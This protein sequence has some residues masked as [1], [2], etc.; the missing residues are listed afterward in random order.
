MLSVSYVNDNWYNLDNPGMAPQLGD[1]VTNLYDSINPGLIEAIYGFN[2]FGSTLHFDEFDGPVYL[3]LPGASLIHDA[4]QSAAPG[5]TVQLLDGTFVESD[6]VIDRPLTLAGTVTGMLNQ[7]SVIVPEVTSAASSADFGVGTRQGIIIYSPSV[8][9]S[10]VVVNGSGSFATLGSQQYHQGITTIYDLQDGGSYS[11]LRNGL[12][13]PITLGSSYRFANE[14]VPSLLIDNVAVY[15]SSYRGITLSPLADKTWDTGP[16]QASPLQIS[17]SLVLGIGNFETPGSTSTGIVLQ[18]IGNKQSGVDGNIVNTFVDRVGI[19]ILT[20]PFGLSPDFGN[21]NAAHNGATLAGNTV[22]FTQSVGYQIEF[23]SAED[24]VGNHFVNESNMPPAPL[25]AVGFSINH[26]R[27]NFRDTFVKGAQKGFLVQN[28][29]FD[30]GILPT[31]GFGTRLQ[32]R[33]GVPADIGVYLQNSVSSPHSAAA[34]IGAGASFQ[35]YTVAV[36]SSQLTT[37][38]DNRQNQLVV[39][40]PTFTSVTTPFELFETE[41]Q[42]QVTL[43]GGSPQVVTS[44]SVLAP[45]FQN[46]GYYYNS[47]GNSS[48]GGI[49]ETP[50]TAA[51]FYLGNGELEDGTYAPL[52]TGQSGTV[53]LF[54]FNS[55]RTF[56]FSGGPPT[57]PAEGYMLVPTAAT[58]NWW[59]SVV[60][61]GSGPLQIM[62]G[63]SNVAGDMVFDTF[64]TPV[65]I[66]GVPAYQLLPVD[67][68]AQSALQVA[69]RKTAGNLSKAFQVGLIDNRGNVMLYAFPFAD[70]TSTSYTTL[71]VNL[72]APSQVLTGPDDH[73]DFTKVVGYVITSDEGEYDGIT[74][75][76]G[77]LVDDISAVG[78]PN[79]VIR[80]PQASISN[81]ALAPELRPS[82]VPSI[83]QQFTIVN[84]EGVDPVTGTFAG[85]AE[86]SFVTIS[87]STYKISYTGGSGN[88]VV[89]TREDVPLPATVVGRRL[90][91]NQSGTASPLRYDGNNAAIN[92]YDDLAIATDKSAYLPGSGASTFANV[93]SYTKGINGIMIDIAGS[94][95]TIT[96]ADFI[97]RVGN[98]N[99]PNSWVA[100]PAPNSISVR[101]GAGIGGSDRVVLTWANG[102]I[103]KKWLEVIVLAN[104]N[105]GLAQKPGYPVG[106][107]DV[108]FFGHALADTGAGNTATQAN[109][110]VTDELG[111]RNNPA[112]IFSNVPITNLYDFNRDAQVNTTDALTA[113]NNPTNIGNVTRFISVANPP[114]APEASA[115]SDD[116]AVASALA[117]PASAGALSSPGI[118]RWLVN[119]LDSIELSSGPI[120]GFLQHASSE[121]AS[122]ARKLPQSAT[123]ASGGI[124]GDDDLLDRLLADLGL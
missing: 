120:L 89:L 27:G 106:Q 102:D 103:S 119:R 18:N 3:S 110:S 122:A 26:S 99:T 49:V 64:N 79:S 83:G 80:G 114:T 50:A 113:R 35:D 43:P 65:V 53:P 22:G 72:L 45:G 10:S 6:I 25:N 8:T 97:F 101:A 57:V 42:G 34:V 24:Y 46:S 69:A 104:A 84:N 94:H 123:A 20:R 73:F 16:A 118:A 4:I 108:F 52:I 92:V 66:E 56:Q 93:S 33:I 7:I 59:G 14:T 81:F 95:G 105:T 70:L 88:D 85:Q 23:G 15:A 112:S 77:L 74:A 48:G 91:Y 40:R 29:S 111:A 13:P 5:D 116:G 37:P 96:A 55:T 17:D 115:A 86:G 12:L 30:D 31:L 32:G 71:T 63:V 109:V 39:D 60:Q 19:G 36:Y 38:S 62:G 61:N 87:G 28:T 54:N 107:G 47:P 9:V 78:I 21:P 76:F 117:A 44:G 11:S 1:Q 67:I 100:G 124:V 90:F 68:S 82:F 98:N 121:R 41:L 2:A 58:N 51:E 75:P